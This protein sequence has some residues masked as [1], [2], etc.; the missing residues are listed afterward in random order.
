VLFAA[1]VFGL[2]RLVGSDT[3]PADESRD[4]VEVS[5]VDNQPSEPT[6]E[7]EPEPTPEPPPKP[8]PKPKP[9]PKPPEPEKPQPEPDPDPPDTTKPEPVEPSPGTDTQQKDDKPPEEPTQQDPVDLQG[10][11]MSSTVEG[12]E[13]PT[14]KVGKGVGSGEVTDTY[15]SPDKLDQTG[16]GGAS[17]SGDPGGSG[18]G[19][20]TGSG[21]PQKDAKL[22][23]KERV[24]ESEYPLA[25]KRR[26]IEGTV[27]G[28]ATIDENGRVTQVKVVQSVGHGFDE[29]ATE[30]F[31]KWRF[32]PAQRGCQPVSTKKR[33]SHDFTLTGR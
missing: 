10:L 32:E 22:V 20:G 19:G 14:M 8:D 30:A 2:G 28:V 13:G 31:K 11:E 27:V 18:S 16:G 26:G 6:P 9:A 23:N 1:G 7:P 15:V 33:L 5:V 4:I 25:A 12:G 3:D 21:C 24:P 29:L 17:G